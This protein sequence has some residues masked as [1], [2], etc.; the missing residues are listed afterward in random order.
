MRSMLVISVASVGRRLKG[1]HSPRKP[2]KRTDGLDGPDGVSLLWHLGGLD[3]AAL[4]RLARELDVRVAPILEE[5]EQDR[6]EPLVEATVGAWL[7]SRE[8]RNAS[9][10]NTLCVL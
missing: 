5:G 9:Y 3:D 7:A 1:S 4:V 10:T 2:D 8:A 6:D